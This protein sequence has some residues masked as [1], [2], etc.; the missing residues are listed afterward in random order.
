MAFLGQKWKKQGWILIG[1][2][3][4]ALWKCLY[5]YSKMHWDKDIS[6]FLFILWSTFGGYSNYLKFKKINFFTK[7]HTLG[8]ITHFSTLPNVDPCLLNAIFLSLF[9]LTCIET[10]LRSV[11]VG[12]QISEQ[13]SYFP[14]QHFLSA[15]A[16]LHTF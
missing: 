5:F 4:F 10:L 3:K 15:S 7:N 6:I 12:L 9:M 8:M 11:L 13:R 1:N 16:F 14:L 2:E